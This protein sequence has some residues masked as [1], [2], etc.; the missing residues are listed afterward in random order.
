MPRFIV[1]LTASV[2]I[3]FAFAPGPSYATSFVDDHG[4]DYARTT[5][6]FDHDGTPDE[7]R[8]IGDRDRGWFLAV[9][10]SS[11]RGTLISDIQDPGI[12]K[13]QVWIDIDGD[14]IP[15]YC[16][17]IG[18]GD[19]QKVSC[20]FLRPLGWAADMVSPVTDWGYPETR[21]WYPAA[22]GQHGRFCRGIGDHS[23]PTTVCS[24][25]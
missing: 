1:P 17:F 7:L 24:T 15:D 11:T 14:G 5:F 21:V 8:L 16:R 4:Y 25:W 18:G 2:I 10:F 9:S 20:N 12:Q 22:S 13:T 6:D 19:V 23:H 3:L